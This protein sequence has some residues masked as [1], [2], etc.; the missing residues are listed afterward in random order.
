M[1]QTVTPVR[2]PELTA[3]A[4][5]AVGVA[6]PFYFIQVYFLNF[7]TDVLLMAPVTIGVLLMLCRLWDAVS[8][9]LTGYLSDRTRAKI[10]RRRPW[11]FVAAPLVA[12][13]S[14]T[15]WSPPE[16]LAGAYLTVWVAISMLFFITASTFYDI[17]H[18]AL[19]SELNPNSYQRTRLYG[20]RNFVT[21]VGA[22]LA[23]GGLQFVVNAETPRAAAATVALLAG[24]AFIPLLLVTPLFIKERSHS[25]T[26]A[27]TSPLLA[28]KD[29][30]AY[31]AARVLLG[32][33]FLVMVGIGT[34]ATIAPYIAIYVLERPD[35]IG[36]LPACYIGPLVLSIP[37]WVRASKKI[38][39]L[40]LWR[41]SLLGATLAYP[42]MFFID[43]DTV[44]LMVVMLAIAG[45]WG[46][47]TGPL[48][49][50][51][52]SNVIDDDAERTQRPKAGVYFATW[53]F[54]EK[55]ASALIVL[56][57]ALALQFSGF[58]ANESASAN[59][60]LAMRVCLAGLP[61]IA[62]FAAAMVLGRLG[63]SGFS[64][65]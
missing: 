13:S 14:F 54:L 24:V 65:D 5:P 44:W 42:P 32:A 18:Y 60:N 19:A 40:K 17:P 9:P 53:N 8:D 2:W 51:L 52:L 36:L 31:P 15:V 41:F 58:V 3:Y 6:T 63:R 7:A 55:A 64:R 30:F 62:F 26:V 21:L 11:L 23:F 49:P 29:V 45:V 16:A 33:R 27:I 22:G 39:R 4:V 48:G 50:S 46:G 1:E 20:L 12:V 38:E 61:A 59:T 34:Q 43:D 28:M 35:L 57:I 25:T 37:L 47:A 10:G 56:V